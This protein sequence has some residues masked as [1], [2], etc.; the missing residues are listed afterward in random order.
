MQPANLVL[1]PIGSGAMKGKAHR[2]NK[3]KHRKKQPV[4]AARQVRAAQRIPTLGATIAALMVTP[5]TALGQSQEDLQTLKEVQVRAQAEGLEINRYTVK[6]TKASKFEQDVAEVPQ[7]ITIVPDTLMTD[8]NATT[9][10]EAMKNVPSVTFNSGE[11]GRIGDNI[12]IRG[13]YTF[14]DMYVD[15]M[16]DTAQYNR[17]TFNDA[18]IEVL[19]GSAS[20]LF[21]RGQAGGVINQIFKKAYLA[22]KS[23]VSVIGGSFDYFRS[24]ADV[25]R[26][27]NREQSS[28]VRINAVVQDSASSR[29]QV[30]N[31]TQGVAPTYSW[32]IGTYN[33]ID[34][35]YYYLKTNLVPDYGIGF[36]S[37]T[38]NPVDTPGSTFSGTI[39]DIENNVTQFGTLS[40]NYSFDRDTSLVTK[41]KYSNYTRSLWAN[42][43]RGYNGTTQAFPYPVTTLSNGGTTRGANE[44]TLAFQSDFNKTGNLWGMGHTVMAGVEYYR[45]HVYRYNY[46]SSNCQPATTGTGT[47]WIT[48]NN[49]QLIN[50]RCTQGYA[51]LVKV[52]GSVF[53]YQANSYAIYGQDMVELTRGVK[54]MGGIRNDWMNAVYNQPDSTVASAMKNQGLDYSS[55]SYR[56]GLLY[57]PLPNFGTFY[58]SWSDSFSPTADLYQL[59]ATSGAQLPAETS[60]LTEIGYKGDINDLGL[61]FRATA[62]HQVKNYERNTDLSST[63]ALRSTRRHT[64]GLEFEV[65]GSITEKWDIFSGLGLMDSRIDIPANSAAAQ[66]VGQAPSNSTP[67]TYNLWTTYKLPYGWKVGGGVNGMGRRNVYG[68]TGSSYNAPN[69]VAAQA[70]VDGLIQYDAKHYTL[71]L[72]AYNLFNTTNYVSLYENG[73]FAVPGT[74]Q[75][76]QGALIVKF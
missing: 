48:V 56:A 36:N 27:V 33:Q 26:V 62:Y 54:V 7:A 28:A 19:R 14:G 47:A 61:S 52:P 15:G 67:Y 40:Q 3:R 11:G 20:M 16:R 72:N 46:D 51:N 6:T 76:F 59:S 37:Q 50:D 18:A 69:W 73:G 13:F 35:S 57:E 34:A 74:Y 63:A 31:H 55:P 43:G 42:K 39:A 58:L 12:N 5:L 45:E 44:E 75:A 65:T 70:T 10:E 22:D 29:N 49:N 21:G 24:T 1:H 71:R 25:N 64:D 4:T 66:M 60:E 9:L 68:Q 38:K 2:M 17:D 8:Q 32:G 23:E 41:L 53:S 30:T